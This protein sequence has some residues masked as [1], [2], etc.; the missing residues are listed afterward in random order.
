MK[1][2]AKNLNWKIQMKKKQTISLKKLTKMNWLVKITKRFVWFW[3]IFKY[4]GRDSISA[5]AFLVVIPIGIYSKIKN[6]GNNCS[7][8]RY[9]PIIKKKNV[10]LAKS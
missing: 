7:N 4:L 8:K 1:T 3:L 6:M 10:L 2:E 9:K 5:F